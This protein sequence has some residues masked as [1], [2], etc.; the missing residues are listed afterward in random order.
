MLIVSNIL[1]KIYS[2][3]LYNLADL[4]TY[5]TEFVFLS[6]NVTKKSFSYLSLLYALTHLYKNLNTWSYNVLI[7]L[8]S[9]HLLYYVVVFRF[10]IQ[11]HNHSLEIILY[12]SVI[13]HLNHN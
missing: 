11:V 6:K 9:F 10:N 4:L 5:L 13:E 2:T 12:A 1:P 7:N 8:S 3:K